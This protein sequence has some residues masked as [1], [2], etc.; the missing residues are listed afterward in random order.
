MLV[1]GLVALH[2]VVLYRRLSVLPNEY[3]RVSAASA[4]ERGLEP[5]DLTTSEADSGCREGEVH[6]CGYQRLVLAE[7]I[8]VREQPC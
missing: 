5:G 8:E 4:V 1:F 3:C 6:L 7:V 2:D